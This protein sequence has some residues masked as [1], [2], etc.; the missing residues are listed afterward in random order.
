MINNNDFR[1]LIIISYTHSFFRNSN[2]TNYGHTRMTIVKYFINIKYCRYYNIMSHKQ[3][4]KLLSKHKLI[5]S[6]VFYK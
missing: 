1:V 5:Y 6:N 3:P 2:T 4:H